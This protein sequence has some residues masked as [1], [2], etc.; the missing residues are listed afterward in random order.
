[1]RAEYDFSKARKEPLHEAPQ[2]ARNHP[3]RRANRGLLQGTRRGIRD[4]VPNAHQSLL[5]RL[6]GFEEGAEFGVA[7]GDHRRYLTSEVI[8]PLT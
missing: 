8:I 3:L 1:M 4:S 7:R 6:R 2:E 5:A